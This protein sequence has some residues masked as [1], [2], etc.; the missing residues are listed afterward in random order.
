M[1]SELTEKFD[2]QIQ[3]TLLYLLRKTGTPNKLLAKETGISEAA[4]SHYVNGKRSPYAHALAKI[5]SF[6]DC[7]MDEMFGMVE[8]TPQRL[9]HIQEHRKSKA[10]NTRRVEYVPYEM[11]EQ[12]QKELDKLIAVAREETCEEN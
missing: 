2:K 8:I 5:A 3:D 4:I 10:P 12:E 6:F 7:T 1:G 11:S 9:K